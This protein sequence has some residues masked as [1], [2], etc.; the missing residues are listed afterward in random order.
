MKNLNQANWQYRIQFSEKVVKYYL[1]DL[2]CLRI[3]LRW[4]KIEKGLE[5]DYYIYLPISECTINLKD[6][7]AYF[8]KYQSKTFQLVRSEDK[9]RQRNWN[10]K[11]FIESRILFN[12][13]PE[14]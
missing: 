4:D 9:N 3:N 10:S 13:A 6:K 12:E 8:D 7:E 1:N 14:E 11:R 5:K 2:D